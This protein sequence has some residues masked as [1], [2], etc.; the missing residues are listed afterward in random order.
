MKLLNM[1]NNVRHQYEW[2]FLPKRLI[3]R[4]S[5]PPRENMDKLNVDTEPWKTMGTLLQLAPTTEK[6][7]T[8][9]PQLISAD[10]GPKA[11]LCP[12]LSFSKR[13]G[14]NLQPYPV[15]HLLGNI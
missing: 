1:F 14:H 9:I 4:G 13:D 8:Y 12:C 11:V 7:V 5:I 6:V 10:P 3:L 15:L 2:V